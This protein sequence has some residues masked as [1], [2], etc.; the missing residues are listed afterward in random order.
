M[1]AASAARKRAM[2]FGGDQ[3]ALHMVKLGGIDGWIQFDQ[4]VTRLDHCAIANMNRAHY[5][6][7]GR[8]DHLGPAI[9]NNLSRCGC[10]NV[11]LA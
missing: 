1:S 8:L 3:I 6:R 11:D 5:S 4:Y 9:H 10:H 7:F 2:L